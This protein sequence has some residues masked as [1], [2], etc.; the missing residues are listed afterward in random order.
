MTKLKTHNLE[1]NRLTKLL[2]HI[3]GVVY[4]LRQHRDGNFS[5][6]YASE[7]LWNIYGLHLEDVE[8]DATPLFTAIH[9]EDY[10]TVLQ[11]L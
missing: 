7:N 3:P 10:P 4:E 1:Q 5:L 11:S 6:P 9:P 8:N 2:R